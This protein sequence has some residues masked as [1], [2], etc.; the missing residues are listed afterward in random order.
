[1]LQFA[2]FAAN[3]SSMALICAASA[4]IA[5]QWLSVLSSGSLRSKGR[6]PLRRS[7]TA[8]ACDR[9]WRGQPIPRRAAAG[10]G[11]ES[12]RTGASSSTLPRT[13]LAPVKPRKRP[14]DSVEP[15]ADPIQP[16]S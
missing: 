13:L 3:L 8:R 4:L 11:P 14:L 1:M 2:N 15:R 5:R 16:F 12:R 6:V 7:S 9:V 10:S